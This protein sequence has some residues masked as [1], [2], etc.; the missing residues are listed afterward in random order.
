MRIYTN[1]FKNLLYV[2]QIITYCIIWV[3]NFLMKFVE[4]FWC[5]YGLL[6]Y[7]YHAIIIMT[8]ML[9]L[10][11]LL[12]CVTVHKLTEMNSVKLVHVSL[13]NVTIF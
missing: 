4:F 13:V 8:I 3:G 1:V 7:Y 9:H 12:V 6:Y 11:C 10:C 2:A 5:W